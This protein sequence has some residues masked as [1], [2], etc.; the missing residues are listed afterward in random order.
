MPTFSAHQLRKTG[1]DKVDI[2]EFVKFGLDC[3]IATDDGSCGFEGFVTDCAEQWLEQPS[4][5][6]SEGIM[7]AC[8]PEAMLAAAADLAKRLGLDCQ[9]SMER[10]MACGIGLC[11]SCAVKVRSGQEGSEYK[12]CC[13][14]GPVFDAKDVIFDA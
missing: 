4:L 9:V 10:M 12:L 1:S 7:Y 3:H 5:K 11:Q 14:D 13:T 8:G 6:I 2:E